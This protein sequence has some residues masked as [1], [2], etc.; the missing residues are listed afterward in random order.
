[1][2]LSYIPEER[3][4]EGVIKDFSVA[5]NAVLHGFDQNPFAWKGFFLNL[6]AIKKVTRQHII[7]YEIK[8]PST[9]TPVKSL[10]GG[11]IQ[12]LVLARELS[13]N[14]RV[15]IAAQPTR[16]VDIGATEYIHR[17]LL[18]ARKDGVAILLISE[19]LDEILALSDRIVVMYEGQIV[20]EVS[21]AE[22]NVNEIGLM[23]A[24]ASL[25]E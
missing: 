18:Q 20:G 10:S 9:E 3:M 15:L 19:D 6:G 7:D 25:P 24:G 4:I 11:N 23:M 21:R 1:M 8:T 16:G 13:R 22:A 2:G 17:R 5:E 12:K 14:P